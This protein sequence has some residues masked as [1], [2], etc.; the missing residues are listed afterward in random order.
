MR[1]DGGLGMPR[2][3]ASFNAVIREKVTFEQD[4]KMMRE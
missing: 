4:L 2:G 3:A 1:Q